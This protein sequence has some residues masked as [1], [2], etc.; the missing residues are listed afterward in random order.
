[1]E[2][3]SRKLWDELGRRRV[4]R[5]AAAYGVVSFVMLQL[6]EILMPAYGF[7]PEGLRALIAALTAG[8][9]LVLAASWVYDVSGPSIRRTP[10]ADSPAAGGDAN[11]PPSRRAVAAVVG[12]AAIVGAAGWWL[13]GPGMT[14]SLKA[15][16]PAVLASAAMLFVVGRR[17]VTPPVTPVEPGGPSIAVMPFA[18]WGPLEDIDPGVALAEQVRARLEQIDGLVVAPRISAGD[19][20]VLDTRR[21]GRELGVATILEGSVLRYGR[22]TRVTVQL[23][24]IRTAFRMWSRTYG[25]DVDGPL[26]GHDDIARAVVDEIVS[27]RDQARPLRA[28]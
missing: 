25:F 1:M 8:L 7:G 13:A 4:V 23:V 17:S 16:L 15:G 24:D 11:A 2:V 21:L 3:L 5:S 10:A 18:F 9:P 27:M 12:A 26:A 22:R 20:G 28:V 14:S 6:G 19:R